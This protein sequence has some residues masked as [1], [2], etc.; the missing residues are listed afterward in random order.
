MAVFVK[1]NSS[2]YFESWTRPMPHSL[3]WEFLEIL[4]DHIRFL[5]NN[6]WG[7]TN[8]TTINAFPM[9]VSV[10]QFKCECNLNTKKKKVF[11]KKMR[12]N[13]I[14]QSIGIL[15]RKAFSNNTYSIKTDWRW[16]EPRI[17]IRIR[18][19]QGL[20]PQPV[21]HMSPNCTVHLQIRLRVPGGTF[22]F[23]KGLYKTPNTLPALN[24]KEKE[25]H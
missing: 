15:S 14:R 8:A 20:L 6:Y 12:K 17:F 23:L 5:Q 13:R 2:S 16:V 9:V 24:K 25:R 10:A 18:S 21:H 11:F 1:R 19:V 3:C 22:V 7:N 4:L